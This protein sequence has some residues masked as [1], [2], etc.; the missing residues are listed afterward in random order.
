MIRSYIFVACMLI[1]NVT[2]CMERICIENFSPEPVKFSLIKQEINGIKIIK[3]VTIQPDFL[4]E[5][6]MS[7][8]DSLWLFDMSFLCNFLSQN[9]HQYVLVKPGLYKGR[10]I[11]SIP[12][13]VDEGIQLKH[14]NSEN[15]L[16]MQAVVFR[17]G[18]N[19]ESI[20]LNNILCKL[21]KF[22]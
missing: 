15:K 8:Q 2:N 1:H 21:A 20:T 18:Q 22:F 3:T 6:P 17:I 19:I 12:A 11:C 16:D 14:E 5:I 10:I 9:E 7:C 13:I 4:E